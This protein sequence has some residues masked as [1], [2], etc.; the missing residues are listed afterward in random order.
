MDIVSNS[1]K[2]SPKNPPKIGDGFESA[3]VFTRCECCLLRVSSTLQIQDCVRLHCI[4]FAASPV[5]QIEDGD[6][7]AFS[8]AMVSDNYGLEHPGEMQSHVGSGGLSVLT[9]IKAV[10]LSGN[11]KKTVCTY[12]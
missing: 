10:R 9:L 2:L 11:S 5:H 6:M 4:R 1:A 7:S 12:L 3:L 8:S